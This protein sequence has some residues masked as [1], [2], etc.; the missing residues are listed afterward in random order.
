MNE[1]LGQAA[2]AVVLL[3]VHF[4]DGKHQKQVW[5]EALSFLRTQ[6]H[7]NLLWFLSSARVTPVK[8]VQRCPKGSRTLWGSL[9]S[10]G[11]KANQV[12]LLQPG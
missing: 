1:S 5:Q 12:I 3:S 2:P 8:C 10:Q 6:P 7:P 11:L 4:D 9:E